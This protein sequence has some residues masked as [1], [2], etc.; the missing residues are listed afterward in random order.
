MVLPKAVHRITAN[1]LVRPPPVCTL[2]LT[3]AIVN[4]L[5]ASACTQ[6]SIEGLVTIGTPSPIHPACRDHQAL[7]VN[8]RSCVGPSTTFLHCRDFDGVSSLKFS[9]SKPICNLKLGLLDPPI[10]C[11]HPSVILRMIF[12]YWAI[13]VVLGRHRVRVTKMFAMQL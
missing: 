4:D 11:S 13:G 7:T 2:T 12:W 9:D 5:A 8:E 1:I 3:T 6:G 10:S